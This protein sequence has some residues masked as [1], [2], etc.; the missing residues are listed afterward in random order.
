LSA[1]WRSDLVNKEG[2]NQSLKMSA[3]ELLP[4]I[5][6]VKSLGYEVNIEYF[7]TDPFL[8]FEVNGERYYF[9][10]Y[11]APGFDPGF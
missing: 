4:K 1:G 7:Y 6:Y 9:G 5:E 3:P 8:Y 2:W 11:N 10:V